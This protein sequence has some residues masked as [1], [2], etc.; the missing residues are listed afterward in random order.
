MQ[1][2]HDAQKY[3]ID[4]IVIGAPGG[5]SHIQEDE[6]ERARFY[7]GADMLVLLPGVGAQGG[8]AQYIWKHFDPDHVIVNVGRALMFPKDGDHKAAAQY[9]QRTLNELRKV[10]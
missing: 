3:G 7:A 4:G 5:K 6:V 9:Y 10:A 2:A 8:E 1:L